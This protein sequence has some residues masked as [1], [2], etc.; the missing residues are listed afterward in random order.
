DATREA[1]PELLERIVHLP[2]T[3]WKV[4]CFVPLAG[5]A[6]ATG[7]AILAHDL[8]AQAVE[9][10]EQVAGEPWAAATPR[11]ILAHTLVLFGRYEQAN[12]VLDDLEELSH[13]A[14]DL[15]A[16]L[17]GA[18]LRAIID[19][20]T[21]GQQFEQYV[22]HA[23]RAAQLQWEHYGRDLSTM[24]V[25]EGARVRDDHSTI[26]EAATDP[27]LDTFTN[28][29]HGYHTYLVNALIFQGELDQARA[30]IDRLEA[31]EGTAWFEYWGCL[32]WLRAR[33]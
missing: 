6:M 25:V 24:D 22:G 28:T 10:L 8:A 18:A 2:N 29:Q 17:T 13:E 11:I 15:E 5:A 27:Q 4:D 16:R 21:N 1:I 33:L 20:V 32:D 7:D 19:V 12:R 3:P 26:I 14:L 9:L 31:D 30:C 23:T